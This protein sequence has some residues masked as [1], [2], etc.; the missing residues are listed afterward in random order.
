MDAS[1]TTAAAAK[2]QSLDAAPPPPQ[3]PTQP[4]SKW[5]IQILFLTLPTHHVRPHA[6]CDS[7]N[8]NGARTNRSRP[9]RPT[10]R[11]THPALRSSSH[12]P[13]CRLHKPFLFLPLGGGRHGY[14][15]L[16]LSDAEMRLVTGDATLDCARLPLPAR[17]NARITDATVVR[18]L[19]QLQE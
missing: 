6:H 5:S 11:S 7:H 18:A 16:V 15:T 13:T 17:I 3:P 19:L 9:F 8:R 14:L 12:R 4:L 10:Y 2:S 1:A